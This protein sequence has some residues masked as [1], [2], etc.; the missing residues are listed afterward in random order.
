MTKPEILEVVKQML[1]DWEEAYQS[2]SFDTVVMLDC[3]SGFCNYLNCSFKANSNNEV[4]TISLE[5]QLDLM[6]LKSIKESW[7]EDFFTKKSFSSLLPRI[8]HLK[9]TI[10]RLEN[11][12]SNENT[13]P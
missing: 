4:E 12:I 7:Y 10:A 8:Y 6:Q 9:R 11:E 2:K 1:A 13:T 5:L 3:E